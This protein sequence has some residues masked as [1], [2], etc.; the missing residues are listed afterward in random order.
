[1]LNFFQKIG[2]GALGLL[3]WAC[4][5]GLM[6]VHIFFSIQN[7]Q[8]IFLIVGMFIPPIGLINALSWIFSGQSITGWF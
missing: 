1:M 5:G 6:L 2:G 7:S 4:T 3:L 8:I